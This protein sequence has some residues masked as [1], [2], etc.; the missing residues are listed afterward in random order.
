MKYKK[1][2]IAIFCLTLFIGLGYLVVFGRALGQPANHLA[3]ALVL[4]KVIL[5]SEAIKIDNETYLTKDS[6]SF[7]SKMENQGF[8]HIEQ[9]GA[10]Y[11]FE[12]GGVKYVSISK[13]YSSHFRLFSQPKDINDKS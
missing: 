5:S 3:I 11:V 6:L 2:L 1:I 7:I 9:L 13:M 10:A 12:K 4:P 8:N